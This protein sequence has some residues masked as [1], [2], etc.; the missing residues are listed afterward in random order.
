MSSTPD[1]SQLDSQSSWDTSTSTDDPSNHW[2]E[3]RTVKIK[4]KYGDWPQMLHD[5]HG[6]H[7]NSV[8][9]SGEFMPQKGT[10]ETYQSDP[11]N[12]CSS[13]VISVFFFVAFLYSSTAASFT[14]CL[15]KDNNSYILLMSFT[16]IYCFA[17]LFT[18]L[19]FGLIAILTFKTQNC[20]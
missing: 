2:L 10:K 15:I 11:K 9:P 12:A 6:Q 8:Q 17:G 7:S 13:I 14:L 5:C 19:Q 1:Q 3:G 4:C 18:L 16:V 20:L